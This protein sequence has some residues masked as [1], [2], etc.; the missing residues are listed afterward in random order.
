MIRKIGFAAVVLFAA[1]GF[2]AADTFTCTVTKV[3]GDKVTFQKYKKSTEKGKKGE[4]DGPAVT[5]T[6]AKDCKIVKGKFNADKKLEAGDPIE[7]G[8]KAD[9][10]AKAS[11]EKGVGARITTNA[12]N[13]SITEIVVFGGK[14]KKTTK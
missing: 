9:A 14:K 8:L 10:F 1:I 12:D 6:V 13:T 5:L 4:K 2:A 11:E 7:G 3:D